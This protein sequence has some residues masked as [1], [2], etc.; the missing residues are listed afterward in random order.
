MENQRDLKKFC[1]K[2]ISMIR[3][4]I[5]VKTTMRINLFHRIKVILKYYIHIM[6]L[7]EQ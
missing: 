2:R 7:F 6:S 4:Q 3:C 5:V 1:A